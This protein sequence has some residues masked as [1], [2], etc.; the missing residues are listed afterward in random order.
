MIRYCL[1]RRPERRMKD[2]MRDFEFINEVYISV[3]FF[4]STVFFHVNLVIFFYFCL[5]FA[6]FLFVCQSLPAPIFLSFLLFIPTSF[7]LILSVLC[8]LLP[9]PLSLPFISFSCF[10]VLDVYNYVL[11]SLPCP[12]CPHPLLLSPT[13]LSTFPAFAFFH[14]DPLFRPSFPTTF[15]PLCSSYCF[16]LPL[17]S[18]PS[19]FFS[20]APL[21]LHPGPP[22]R[23]GPRGTAEEQG[24][25]GRSGVDECGERGDAG[26]EDFG[27]GDGCRAEDGASCGRKFRW[28]LCE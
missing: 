18:C 22:S 20:C 6:S 9:F 19:L 17:P 7:S 8:I 5:L 10:V 26:G 4:F 25:R 28:Q 24:A 13:P 3:P 12:A 15:P 27:S 21:S 1:V 11:C 14:T 23:S 2:R 16:S